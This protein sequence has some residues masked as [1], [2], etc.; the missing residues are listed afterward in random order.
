MTNQEK[1]IF[2][3]YCKEA[4]DFSGETQKVIYQEDFEALVIELR[5]HH[6]KQGKKYVMAS[7]IIS[8][9]KMLKELQ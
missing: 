4:E 8:I 5:E 7:V 6:I 9:N 1:A 3:K 2:I